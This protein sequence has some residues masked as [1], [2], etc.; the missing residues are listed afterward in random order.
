MFA[1]VAT[2][3]SH[4]FRPPAVTRRQ[5]LWRVSRYGAAALMASMSALDLLARDRGGFRLDGNAPAGRNRRVIILG[6][7]VTGLACAYELRKIGYDCTLLEARQRPGGRNWTVRGGTE[8]TEIGNPR[9]VCHFD[10]GLFMNAGP[11]RISPQHETTLDYCR[12]F[13]IP[14]VPF[15][16]YN[17]AAYLYVE[18]RPRVRIREISADLRGYTAEMLAKVARQGQLDIPLSAEDREK[19]IEYLRADG[20]LDKSLLYAR[21]GEPAQYDAALGHTRGYTKALGADDGP[22]TPT[23]PLELE[24]LIQAGYAS[25]YPYEHEVSQQDTMLTPAGGMDRIPRAFADRLAGVLHYGAEVREVRRTAAGVRVLYA[26]TAHGGAVREETGDLC[27][28]TLPPH[29]LGR[30]PVDFA[31]ATLAAL[32]LGRVERAGK[33][34]LQFKR[35]FWEEDDDI[36]GGRSVTNLPIT[37]IFYPFDGLN[38]GGKGM[39]LGAYHY[40]NARVFADLDPA[41]RERVALAEG[42]KIHPQYPAE[43]ENSFSVEWARIPHNE[44]SWVAWDKSSDCD[45][46]QQVLALPDGPFYFAGDWMSGLNGWQAGA[47][48]SA[49]ETC[50]QLHFRACAG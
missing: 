8:E 19:F 44:G 32:R 24:T 5:F 46:M 11:M 28:C 36:Y 15:L 47:F 31:P 48:V 39:V 42:A 38:A 37:Q 7:G 16:N 22:G 40:S 1:I 2:I 10:E 25:L 3:G 23:V 21:P 27:I 6:G 17:E 34:G 30:L 35:R 13:G 12:Q 41:G 14:L 45:T 26:E 33:M 29:L 9:Q 20:T 49:H 4:L 18:G 50:R 43:F